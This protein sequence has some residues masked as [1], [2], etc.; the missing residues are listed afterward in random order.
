MQQPVKSD[1][2]LSMFVQNIF[3]FLVHSGL[4]SVFVSFC[5]MLAI[6]DQFFVERESNSFIM[7]P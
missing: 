1:R 7:G 5:S 3:S 4:I 6:R 2:Y